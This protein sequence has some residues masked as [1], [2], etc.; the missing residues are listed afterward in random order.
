[1]QQDD[2]THSWSPNLLPASEP[3]LATRFWNVIFDENCRNPTWHCKN[4][5]CGW[6][7]WHSQWFHSIM[8]TESKKSSYR[9]EWFYIWG[10]LVPITTPEFLRCLLATSPSLQRPRGCT[11]ACDIIPL[12]ACQEVLPLQALGQFSEQILS[13][14]KQMATFTMTM[15]I[16]WS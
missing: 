7:Y 14:T 11:G 6:Q 2:V 4:S 16:L 3:I 9:F 13:T 15:G 1:M 10:A 12:I 5:A 8:F